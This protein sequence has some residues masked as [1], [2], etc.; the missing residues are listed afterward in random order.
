MRERADD[1][2]RMMLIHAIRKRPDDPGLRLAYAAWLTRRGDPRGEYIKLACTRPESPRVRELFA[3]HGHAWIG[4]LPARLRDARRTVFRQGFVEHAWFVGTLED[5]RAMLP[6]LAKIG[7]YPTVAFGVPGTPG[8]QRAI[9][10]PDGDVEIESVDRA[11]WLAR[12]DA[13]AVELPGALDLRPAPGREQ[14]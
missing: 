3:R 1:S 10:S 11:E 7:P 9:V 6:A 4:E 14:R 12:F 2:V 13:G 8:M 5:V